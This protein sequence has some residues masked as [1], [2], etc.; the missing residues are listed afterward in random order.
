MQNS[1]PDNYCRRQHRMQS[2]SASSVLVLYVLVSLG[3]H[4]STCVRVLLHQSVGLDRQPPSRRPS[5]ASAR[6]CCQGNPGVM[7]PRR[8]HTRGGAAR[9]R[10]RVTH[11]RA[12]A[13][14]GTARRAACSRVRYAVARSTG[15]VISYCIT[16]GRILLVQYIV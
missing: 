12:R 3:S 5:R 15:I 16:R 8:G 10:R 1:S 6:S 4:G 11:A 2:I 7:L 9:V 14:T 13:R